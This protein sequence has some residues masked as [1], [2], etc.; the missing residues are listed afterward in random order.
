MLKLRPLLLL[1][2]ALGV[3]VYALLPE[4]T[5]REDLLF[6]HAFSCAASDDYCAFRHDFRHEGQNRWSDLQNWSRMDSLVLE[7][8][9][10]PPL[11]SL[12]FKILVYDADHTQDGIDSTLRPLLKEFPVSRETRRVS[13]PLS[14]FYVP[15]YWETQ[16]PVDKNER[17]NLSKRYAVAMWEILPGWDTP[18]GPRSWETRAVWLKGASNAPFV[19]LV[20]YLCVLISISVGTRIHHRGHK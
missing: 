18:P 7:I 6:A 13:I 15:P 2:G 9:A 19:A 20:V 4:R 1:L 10:E 3:A 5:V 16:H 11:H 14:A 17:H 8:S 12:V